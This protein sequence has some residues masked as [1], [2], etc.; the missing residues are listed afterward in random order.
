MVRSIVLLKYELIPPLGAWFGARL[1][2]VIRRENDELA[3]DVIVPVPL[4]PD[5]LRE[6][7]YNQAELIARP[8]ARNLG[9]PM[10]SWLLMR[11]KPRPE[12]QKLTVHERWESVR[13]AFEARL[14]SPVDNLSVLL[15]DDVMTTGATM[16]ACARVLRRAGARR[17]I[18]LAVA[19]AARNIK[20]LPDAA[21]ERGKGPDEL[22]SA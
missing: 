18:A 8:L 20:V 2:E 11:T 15:V 19:R 13:G 10:R 1:A 3:A 7:G 21:V 5:R 9:L 4:H 16:D 22:E 12:K 6:R 14:G 17:V